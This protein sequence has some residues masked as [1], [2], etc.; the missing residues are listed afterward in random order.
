MMNS[1]FSRLKIQI[2]RH[3]VNCS[4]LDPPQSLHSSGNFSIEFTRIW[5]QVLTA[6]LALDSKEWVSISMVSKYYLG[7]GRHSSGVKPASWWSRSHALLMKG[8]NNSQ[9]SYW[10][11]YPSARPC[12]FQSLP[13]GKL[14]IHEF[15]CSAE[16]SEC[17]LHR[18][19]KEKF[20]DAIGRRLK[21][22]YNMDIF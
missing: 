5:M 17:V 21:F 12:Q 6:V 8:Q 18:I 9:I 11:S 4:G 15:V 2:R 3:I 10:V 13:V 19:Y 7:W 16:V 22:L 20:C 1:V 14:A